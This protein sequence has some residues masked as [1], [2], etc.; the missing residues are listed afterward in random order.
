M[1]VQ[2]GMI[3]VL[4]F[5]ARVLSDKIPD[6][7]LTP[8]NNYE[9][10]SSLILAPG[11][12]IGADAYEPLGKILQS[13]FAKHDIGLYFG[14]PHMNGN[15]TT[16]G[17]KGAIKRV[18]QELQDNGIP[19]GPSLTGNKNPPQVQAKSRPMITPFCW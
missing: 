9:K 10:T 18:A 11:F 15:I 19:A 1:K 12:G 2:Y 14:V 4:M 3:L 8:D 7:V 5:L 6:I 17:L 13:N 16:V